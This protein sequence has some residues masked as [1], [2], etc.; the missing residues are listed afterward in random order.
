MSKV[1]LSGVRIRAINRWIM[2]LLPGKPGPCK[3]GIHKLS[4]IMDMVNYPWVQQKIP[5]LCDKYAKGHYT[6]NS[7]LALNEW[8]KKVDYALALTVGR[9]NYSTIHRLALKQ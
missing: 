6:E 9:P 3:C 1:G 2:G 7:S 4:R 8:A 5:G